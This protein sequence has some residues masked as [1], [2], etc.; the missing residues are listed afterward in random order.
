MRPVQAAVVTVT[1]TFRRSPCRL[2]AGS[3]STQHIPLEGAHCWRD[4]SSSYRQEKDGWKYHRQEPFLV[5]VF[6]LL[7]CG[8]SHNKIDTM[9]V[10]TV[11]CKHIG[12]VTSLR[13]LHQTSLSSAGRSDDSSSTLAAARA[14]SSSGGG[15]LTDGKRFLSDGSV[16]D[17]ASA[18]VP[19]DCL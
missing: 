18:S 19:C 10:S 11:L 14:D 5:S 2:R 17:P 12:C 4:A 13:R 7:V 9:M 1:A 3:A 6:V 8:R 15:S 16:L